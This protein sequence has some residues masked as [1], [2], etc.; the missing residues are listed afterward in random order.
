MS[1][2]N[3]EEGTVRLPAAEFSKVRKRVEDAVR[4]EKEAVFE[5]T[6][7]VWKGLSRKERTDGAAYRQAIHRWRNGARSSS[8]GL[9]RSMSSLSHGPDRGSMRNDAILEALQ[10]KQSWVRKDG[11]GGAEFVAGPPSRVLKADM[12]FPT[13]RTSVFH[14]DGATVTFDRDA[15][16]V[17]YSSGENNHQVERARGT[18]LV[19]A[20]LDGLD[21]VKWTRDT[22]G[23]FVGNDEYNEDDREYGGGANYHTDAFGPVGSMLAP[24]V[25]RPYTMASGLRVTRDEL[26]EAVTREWMR[27]AGVTDW[28]G[29]GGRQGRKPK[30]TPVGGQ[31]TGRTRSGPSVRLG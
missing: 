17:T 11:P 22:G 31:F 29:G 13:N 5:G 15:S 16:T 2:N 10:S 14:E 7:Q 9:S 27:K 28:S 19:G 12:D 3:W 18:V 26:T 20:L 4:V 21:R 1:N 24:G 25:C 30:G 23:V 6:Q 8:S